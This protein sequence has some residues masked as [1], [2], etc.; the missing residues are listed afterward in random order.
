MPKPFREIGGMNK[1]T[2]P[3]LQ[4]EQNCFHNKFLKGKTSMKFKAGKLS[5]S[6]WEIMSL[7]I[8]KQNKVI[9]GVKKM[10]K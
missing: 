4:S 10:S 3:I 8:F 6:E 2:T 7:L 9:V 1:P 5:Q